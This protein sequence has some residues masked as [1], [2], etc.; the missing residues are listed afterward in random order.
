MSSVG[1]ID[2]RPKPIP[3]RSR[4][5]ERIRG[6]RGHSEKGWAKPAHFDGPNVRLW[7]KNVSYDLFGNPNSGSC[8]NTSYVADLFWNGKSL[9][10][11]TIS[12]GNS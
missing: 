7:R 1:Q 2:Y 11:V 8:F 6:G 3:A 9:Q 12:G 5:S 10:L 4:P